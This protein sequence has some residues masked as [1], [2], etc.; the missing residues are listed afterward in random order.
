M[1]RWVVVTYHGEGRGGDGVVFELVVACCRR[2]CGSVT[3][4]DRHNDDEDR[5]EDGDEARDGQVAELVEPP[6]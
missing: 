1:R 6:Y 5:R 4:G 2:L 3:R